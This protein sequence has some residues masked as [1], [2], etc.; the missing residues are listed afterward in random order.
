MPLIKGKSKQAFGHNVAAEM[1]AGKSQ[2]QSLAIAYSIKRRQKKAR[3]GEITSPQE[4][5]TNIDMARDDREMEMLRR[6]KMAQGGLIEA[7]TEKRANADNQDDLDRGHEKHEQ[8]INFHDERKADAD[9]ASDSRE[10]D[11]Q[12]SRKAPHAQDID[13]VSEKRTSIDDAMDDR[14]MSMASRREEHEADLNAKSEMKASAD[15]KSRRS[16][17][18]MKMAKG[19]QVMNPKLHEAM[20]GAKSIAEAIRMKKMYADGGMVD[21]S[22]NA[23]EEPN[24]ED[25]L[26]FNAL[27]KENYSETPGL[28]ELDYD[29]SRSVGHDLPDEDDHGRDMISMIRKKM[30]SRA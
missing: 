8:D 6:K 16:L 30:K 14:E 17:D 9:D 18:M 24:H 4:H 27:R 2:P 22:E 5:M 23:D 12:K 15:D 29:T 7:S 28:E 3:G 21:L 19:G 11:M 26:S 13:F 10:M 25:D 1:H 20:K